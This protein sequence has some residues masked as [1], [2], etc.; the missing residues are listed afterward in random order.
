MRIRFGG[1]AALVCA[2]ALAAPATA[3]A[4]CGST[5]ACAVEQA[6]KAVEDA[7]AAVAKAIADAKATIDATVRIAE[8]TL[9]RTLDTVT[10]AAADVQARGLAGVRVCV[11]QGR[12]YTAT[13]RA[14]GT[15][16]CV[17]KKR[18][19]DPTEDGNVHRGTFETGAVSVTT[20]PTGPKLRFLDRS[21]ALTITTDDTG[22][23][24]VT[25]LDSVGEHSAAG[26]TVHKGQ[27]MG[28]GPA[29]T[30]VA[31]FDTKLAGVLDPSQPDDF[32]IDGAVVLEAAA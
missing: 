32:L 31:A 4:Q 20:T 3:P 5:V 13:G 8:E 12:V 21:A 11:L 10:A 1:A 29:Y 28:F 30:A 26:I 18:G 24:Y 27:Y 14:S 17:A 16:E 19:A 23:Y 9:D 25:H 7:E 15:A 22:P 6:N 2:A